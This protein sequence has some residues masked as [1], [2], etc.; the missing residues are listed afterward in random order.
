LALGLT[1]ETGYDR[2]ELWLI[3]QADF[4]SV[5]SFAEKFEKQGDRLDYL[6]LNAGIAATAYIPTNDGWESRYQS[7]LMRD[8]II[9]FHKVYKSIVSQRHFLHYC[10]FPA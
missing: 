3:D 9:N 10:Y 2:A 4:S 5:K 7:T 8:V 1:T 6:I